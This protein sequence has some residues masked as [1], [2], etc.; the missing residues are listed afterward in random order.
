MASGG[1]SATW[2]KDAPEWLL[3][4]RKDI[5]TYEKLPNGKSNPKV[6]KW[7]AESGHSWVKN[8]IT[9][10]W[11]AAWTGA[12]LK[13]GGF[14]CT[15]SLMARSHLDFG[16]P[17]KGEPQIGDLCVTWR[18]SVWAHVEAA[19]ADVQAGQ[20]AQPTIAGLIAELPAIVWPD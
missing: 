9:T 3:E 4:A 10:P 18:D 13:A 5:G 16:A 11:C 2:Y 1:S 7:F 14:G 15:G 8:A 12:K 6:L 19:F 17:V 20:R